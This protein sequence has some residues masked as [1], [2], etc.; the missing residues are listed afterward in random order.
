VHLPLAWAPDGAFL[1]IGYG[2]PFAV[3]D[4]YRPPATAPRSLVGVRILVGPAPPLDVEAEL[5]RV[6]RHQ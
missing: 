6:M 2:R 1:T 3:T 4:A 5:A